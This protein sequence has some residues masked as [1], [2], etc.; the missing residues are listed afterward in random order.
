MHVKRLD[1]FGLSRG[2]DLVNDVVYIMINGR[3]F[4]SVHKLKLPHTLRVH[5]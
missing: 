4:A 5:V 2:A 3:A 1:L